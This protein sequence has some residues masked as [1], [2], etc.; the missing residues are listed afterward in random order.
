MLMRV[1]IAGLVAV[2]FLIGALGFAITGGVN[3]SVCSVLFGITAALSLTEYAICIRAYMNM[4][5]I[6][7]WGSETAKNES[8]CWVIVAW[9]HLFLLYLCL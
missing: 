1:V 6:A 5:A 2:E 4:A 8:Y 3:T 7:D 9:L